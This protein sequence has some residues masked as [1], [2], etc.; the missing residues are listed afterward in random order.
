MNGSASRRTNATY[1]MAVIRTAMPS[2]RMT[3]NGSGDSISVR[4]PTSERLAGAAR[5]ASVGM[6]AIGRFSWKMN[7]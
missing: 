6:A 7:R 5:I 4:Y 1:T 3:G 2:R